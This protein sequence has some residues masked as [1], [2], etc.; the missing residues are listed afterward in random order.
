MSVT[1]ANGKHL[2]NQQHETIVTVDKQLAWCQTTTTGWVVVCEVSAK[3]SKTSDDNSGDTVKMLFSNVSCTKFITASTFVSTEFGP[4]GRLTQSYT[5]I[6]Y[7]VVLNFNINLR[8]LY[9]QRKLTRKW[10]TRLRRQWI[11]FLL[12]ICTIRPW[13]WL[14]THFIIII[15]RY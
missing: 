11:L 5:N 14:F 3:N 13:S 8:K 1:L 2:F 10:I 7:Q 9:I 6:R 12:R 15:A 4:M